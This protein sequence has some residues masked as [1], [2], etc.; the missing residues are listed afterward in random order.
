VSCS[1][2]TARGFTTIELVAVIVLMGLLAVVLL[3]RLDSTTGQRGDHWR[4]QVLAAL[5]AAQ[6]TALSHRRLVCATVA[7]DAVTLTIATSNPASACASSLPGP[8]GNAAWARDTRGVATAVT[9]GGVLYFQPDGRITSDGAGSTA[10]DRSIT[11]AGQT[12][13]TVVGETGHVR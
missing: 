9:P 7:T 5:R 2:R 1:E 13:I 4:D 12:S 3:P 6:G 8:D 10:I 11:I